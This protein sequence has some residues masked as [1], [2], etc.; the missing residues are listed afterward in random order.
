MKEY[1][2]LSKELA[3]LLN[4]KNKE[5]NLQYNLFNE[6][7]ELDIRLFFEYLYEFDLLIQKNF[8]YRSS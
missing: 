4:V 8:Y 5:K 6:N 1:I 3:E 2:T 7:E